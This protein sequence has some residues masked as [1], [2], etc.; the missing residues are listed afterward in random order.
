MKPD[1]IP[2]ELIDDLWEYPRVI[3]HIED[4]WGK[5]ALKQYI[6]DLLS[7]TRDNSRKGFPSS[8]VL[9]LISLS[10]L[11][12]QYLES[13]GIEFEIEESFGTST[14]KIPKNFL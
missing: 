8:V 5:L 6:S 12:T 4:M 10:N 9:A 3:L 7:D 11:N 1:P 2:P 13:L 14:W